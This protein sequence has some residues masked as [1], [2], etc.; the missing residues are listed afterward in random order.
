MQEAVEEAGDQPGGH[1]RGRADVVDLVKGEVGMGQS[2]RLEPVHD[3]GHDM[4][5]SW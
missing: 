4:L 5:A 3:L 1:E 2:G